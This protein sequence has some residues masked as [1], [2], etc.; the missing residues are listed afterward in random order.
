MSKITEN[1]EE[2]QLLLQKIMNLIPKNEQVELMQKVDNLTYKNN[3]PNN[4]PKN[5]KIKNK[6]EKFGVSNEN[7]CLNPENM[8]T[9]IESGED[10]NNP[11]KDS[12]N[13]NLNKQI[14]LKNMSEHIS[15]F[16]ETEEDKE[17]TISSQSKK[18]IK[19]KQEKKNKF[20]KFCGK[21]RKNIDAPKEDQNEKEKEKEKENEI[22]S[23]N[24]IKIKIQ[25]DLDLDLGLEN[26]IK[27]EY[28]SES[29]E[30]PEE[31]KEEESKKLKI[32]EKER[33]HNLVKKEGFLKIFNYLTTIPLNRKNPL[34]KEID[35]IIT[36][37][38]LL[39]TSLILFQIKFEE[40]DTNI[41]KNNINSNNNINNNNINITSNTNTNININN[42]ISPTINKNKNK[43]KSQIINKK[44]NEEDIQIVIDGVDDESSS[45]E[46]QIKNPTSLK[47]NRNQIINNKENTNNSSPKSKSVK[48]DVIKNKDKEE[49]ELGVH[50]QKDKNGKIY[51]YTKHHYR[52]NR[53][54]D[55]YVYYCADTRCK[56]KGCYYVKSM[57]F[58][59]NKKHQL[60]HDEHC[61]IKNK[62]RFD[63][64][65]PIIDEFEKRDCH[66]AQ[67]FKKDNGSQLVKWYN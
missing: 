57:K 40:S 39:R 21:K 4:L 66:E 51:K 60:E 11:S 5:R 53:G 2:N 16:E 54:N 34:E 12:N 14:E 17:N 64:Y 8:I 67:I 23:N 20:S 47:L 61:Y 3:L 31:S 9:T 13:L 45:K 46:K 41:N 55:I 30:T 7:F 29:I 42:N 26:K 43:E 19:E 35:D 50:L 25:K 44:K 28:N 22:E 63:K 59:C 49:L 36:D 37:I 48:K 27:N 10:S 6:L 52:A 15:L 32:S 65:R 18:N 56:T 33:L 24:N 58:E 1:E 38:G 62:D